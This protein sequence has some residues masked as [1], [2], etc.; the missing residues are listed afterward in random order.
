MTPK[1][2]SHYFWSWTQNLYNCLYAAMVEIALKIPGSG[3]LS[4][5]PTK[6]EC[7]CQWGIPPFKKFHQNSTITSRIISKF[8]K[9]DRHAVVKIPFKYPRIVIRMTTKV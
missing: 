9:I 5:I 1:H 4:G 7:F 3:S 6:I 8:R 2:C